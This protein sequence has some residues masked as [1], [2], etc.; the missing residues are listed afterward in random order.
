MSKPKPI[1]GKARLL[2]CD[3]TFNA[4]IDERSLD[5]TP[6]ALEPLLGSTPMAADCP[7]VS[8][9]RFFSSS[10]YGDSSQMQ[11]ADSGARNPS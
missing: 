3:P 11:I 6:K 7:T 2:R 5:S 10:H 1:D 4:C 8:T 9:A